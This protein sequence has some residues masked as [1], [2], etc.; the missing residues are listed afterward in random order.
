MLNDTIFNCSSLSLW[1]SCFTAVGAIAAILPI[2]CLMVVIVGGNFL[3]VLAVKNEPKLRRQRQNWLIVSLALAD[4]LVGLLVMPLT[5]AYEIIGEWWF[6]ALFYARLTSFQFALIN[7]SGDILCE[8]WLALDVL[9]VTASIL[10]ICA[11]SLDRFESPLTI[12]LTPSCSTCVCNMNAIFRYWSVTQPLSYP[13]KRTPTRMGTMIGSTLFLLF[14]LFNNN[15]CRCLLVSVAVHLSSA[16]IRLASGRS[17]AKSMHAEYRIRICA[18]F[19][20]RVVLHSRHYT[21]A[22]VRAHLQHY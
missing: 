1:P 14:S 10:H 7:F 8:L 15:Y 18:V 17:R 6:G 11:I 22:R 9:F 5:L 12:H 3:V 2:I 4:M 19:R 20:P 21:G 16:A 13:N